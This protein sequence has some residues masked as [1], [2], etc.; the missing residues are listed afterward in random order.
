M[1]AIIFIVTFTASALL[2]SCDDSADELVIPVLN[3][4]YEGTFTVEY[5]A[6][7]QTFSN[8]VTVNFS[9]DSYSS[10][11]GADRFPAGGNGTFEMGE[12][13]VTFSDE[14]FWTAD[15]DWN[16]ILSGEYT[17]TETDTQ[18]ILSATKND[19]GIYTY[20]LMK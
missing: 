1:R 20:E 19:V 16:L 17:V 13:S 9:G 4:A 12:N 3:G 14:N 8:P 10:T 5:L 18:I 2:L 11:S 6:N 7:G 15:F